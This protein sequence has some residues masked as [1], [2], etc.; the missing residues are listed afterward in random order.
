MHDGML[1]MGL[2][3]LAAQPG[4]DVAR[5]LLAVTGGDGDRTLRR[6]HIAASEDPGRAGHHL[7]TDDHRAVGL[8]LDAGDAAEETGVGLLPHRQDQRIGLQLLETAGGTRPAVV[9]QLHHLHLDGGAVDLL[10]RA[11]P[12]ELDPFLQRLVRLELVSRHVGAVTT[13][14]DHRLVH[15]HALGHAGGVHR[16][17]AATVDGDAATEL[18]L[19]AL[20]HALEEAHRVHHAAGIAR[21]DVD[22]LGD[23]GA[24]RDEHRVEIAC[25]LL[26]QHVVDPV[27]ETDLHPHLLHPPDLLLQLPTRHAIGRNAEMDHAARHRTGLADLDRVAQ[28]GQVVGRRQAAGTAADHQHP[29]AAGP[30]RVLRLPALLHRH[31]AEETLDGV[32]AHLLVGEGAVAGVLA[33]VVA[34]PAVDRRKRVVLDQGLPGGLIVAGLGQRQPALDVLASRA[35]VV[36]R[37]QEIHI[38]RTARAKRARTLAEPVG[39]QAGGHILGI[40]GIY[41]FS[42]SVRYTGRA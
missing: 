40:H 2:V 21:R 18:H 5:R 11:Q 35:G 27:I 7:L 4:I 13:I 14:D 3:A 41:Y 30:R 12:V 25:G 1:G 22:L 8:E 20:L 10:D 16:R 24:D 33:G 37:R 9:A 32:D 23:V 17:V 31:I 28:P 6:H 42:Q 26:R 29:L 34:D 38:N 19:L 36:A 39:V 15:A